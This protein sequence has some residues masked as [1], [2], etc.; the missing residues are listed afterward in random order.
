MMKRPFL[1][2]CF[3]LVYL[4]YDTILHYTWMAP[5]LVNVPDG[6]QFRLA[7]AAA[8]TLVPIK[9]VLVYYLIR[10]GIKKILS[11]QRK[12]FLVLLEIGLVFVISCVLFRLAFYYV[13][14]PEIYSIPNKVPLINARSA[15]IAILEMGCA[16]GIA[17]ALKL[18]RLQM[19][20]KEREKNLTKEKLETELKFLRNQTNPHFLFNTL[21]NIYALSRKKSDETPGVVLKLSELL[22]FMLYE[23]GKDAIPV[24]EEIKMVEDYIELQKIRYND[25]LTIQLKKRLDNGSQKIAPMLLLPLVENAFKHGASET[26]FDSIIYINIDLHESYLNFCIENTIENGT[27]SRENGNIG[28]NNI[29]RQLEL[30]Y[31]DYTLNVASGTETFKVNITI[32]LDSYGKV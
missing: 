24:Q 7:V 28:L 20:A 10:I 22:S 27:A 16:G 11:D 12:L 19:A 4:V 30:M 31:K 29:R 13:I 32:N 25:R 3:W 17:I 15:T 8:S 5:V 23:S 9:M 26:R 21:N 1:H 14:Y 6:A 2:F 18:Y